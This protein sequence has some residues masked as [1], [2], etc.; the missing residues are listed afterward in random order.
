MLPPTPTP[1][2]YPDQGNKGLL[3]F[4]YLL[5]VQLAGEWLSRWVGL[6]LP[7]PVLGML[8]M[9]PLLRLDWVAEPVRHCADFVLSHLSLLFIPVGVGIVVHLD[10][11]Y[12]YGL[13]VIVIVVVSTCIALAVSALSF[14][15]LSRRLSDEDSQP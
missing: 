3:G 12:A 10:W 5:T 15:L 9:L 13:P 8:L 4:V 14:L 6:P 7:G 2:P 1:P 11:V